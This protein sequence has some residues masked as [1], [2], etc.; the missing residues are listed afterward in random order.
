MW[1]VSVIVRQDINYPKWP[2]R[3]VNW[4]DER[5]PFQSSDL[6]TLWWFHAEIVWWLD[7]YIL[8]LMA[9]VKSYYQ[10]WIHGR[11][12][13][14]FPK[15]A[16]GWPARILLIWVKRQFGISVF[17]ILCIFVNSRFKPWITMFFDFSSAINPDSSHRF[18]SPVFG[19]HSA[20]SYIS[21]AGHFAKVHVAPHQRGAQSRPAASS[22]QGPWG[23]ADV[24]GVIWKSFG[25]CWE[26]AKLRSSNI[27]WKGFPCKGTCAWS[28]WE[29]FCCCW[30]YCHDATR[31]IA[32]SSG[33]HPKGQAFQT[34]AFAQCAGRC[35][36]GVFFVAP[37]CWR[38]TMA[39]REVT[40]LVA[41]RRQTSTPASTCSFLASNLWWRKWVEDPWAQF[42]C[43]CL[44]SGQLHRTAS[45]WQ[46][47]VIFGPRS[48]RKL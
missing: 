40:V 22:D 14:S 17:W 34:G 35:D 7:D 45:L 11:R 30:R 20:A 6:I 46:F 12:K 3:N 5:R 23:L 44:M 38:D 36:D 48:C 9:K 28:L 13:D 1:W 26:L 19:H 25:T 37:T 39:E 24:T 18:M 10:I 41:T 33:V 8:C 27:P 4:M 47:L 2:P 21:L 43:W 29:G 15:V 42:V 31:R 32:A 16:S